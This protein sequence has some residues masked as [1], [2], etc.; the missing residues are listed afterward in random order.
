[1][2]V[3]GEARTWRL[4]GGGIAVAGVVAGVVVALTGTGASSQTRPLPPTRARAYDARQACL[5]TG[6]RGLADPAAAPVWAGMQD[7]SAAT[8]AKVSYLAV[9]EEQTPA[10]AAPYLAT[11]AARDC[12]VVVA[13]GAAPAGAVSATAPRFPRIQFVVAGGAPG[14]AGPNVTEVTGGRAGVASAVTTALHD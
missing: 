8:H 14:A 12:T 13:V 5:L 7:A 3:W 11:L 1:M 4:L 9:P 10:N 2:K 6:A